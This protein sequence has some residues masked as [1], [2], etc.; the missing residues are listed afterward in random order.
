M[1]PWFAL[2]L[3]ALVVCVGFGLFAW[4]AI[5]CMHLAGRAIRWMLDVPG[6]ERRR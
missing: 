2:F 3:Y 4:L 1:A 6:L 5:V